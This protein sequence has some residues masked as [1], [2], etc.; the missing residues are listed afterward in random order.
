V[1]RPRQWLPAKQSVIDVTHLGGEG[2]RT[3]ML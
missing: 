3:G 2:W 1:H